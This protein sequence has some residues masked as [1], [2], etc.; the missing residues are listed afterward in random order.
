MMNKNKEF[1]EDKFISE[2]QASVAH[3]MAN[4]LDREMVLTKPPS[5]GGLMS[6]PLP[7]R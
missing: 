1:H 5:I 6:C 4:A 2:L 7:D 3:D